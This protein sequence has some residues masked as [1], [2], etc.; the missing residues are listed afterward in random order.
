MSLDSEFAPTPD[1]GEMARLTALVQEAG[2]ADEEIKT[3]EKRIKEKKELRRQLLD[4]V[5]P[6]LMT[7]LGGLT[8]IEVAGYKIEVKPQ[9]FAGIPALSTIEKEKDEDVK[10]EM[11]ARREKALDLLEELAPTL[12]K[13]RYEVEFD[14]DEQE[15]AE[16]FEQELAGME[17]PPEFLAGRSVHPSTL[18]KWIKEKQESGDDLSAEHRKVFGADSRNVAKITR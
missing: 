1:T 8:A 10:Y 9:V 13:R 12:I 3:L 14:R 11:L 17:N 18:V 7:E 5:I 2:S 16:R 6:E 15:A 4:V